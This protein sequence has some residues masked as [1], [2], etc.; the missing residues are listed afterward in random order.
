MAYCIYEVEES[1]RNLKSGKGVVRIESGMPDE[2]IGKIIRKKL[3]QA[4]GAAIT[5]VYDVVTDEM[6][7]AAQKF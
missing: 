7:E 4:A 5:V 1:I 2:H 3:E 6:Q